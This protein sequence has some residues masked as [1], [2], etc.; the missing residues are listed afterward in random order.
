MALV[1]G[2]DLAASLAG[3]PLGEQGPAW[4]PHEVLRQ[5]NQ[6]LKTVPLG[7]L[8]AHTDKKENKIVL[9][10]KEIQMGSGAKSYMRKGFFKYEEIRKFFPIY[11][12]RR[13]L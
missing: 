1:P 3:A 7:D 4:Q 8:S 5:H 12:M 13:P 6:V 11:S 9:I 10:Y 2:G